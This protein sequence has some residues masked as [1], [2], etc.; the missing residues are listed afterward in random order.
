M[1]VTTEERQK[2]RQEFA[3][4]GVVGDFLEPTQ[5]KYTYYLHKPMLNIKGRIVKAINT[6]FG[7]I[8]SSPDYVARMAA[9]GRY[10]YPCGP[11]CSCPWAKGRDWS[12]AHLQPDG[13]YV[14]DDPKYTPTLVISPEKVKELEREKARL[15]E[16]IAQIE[17]ERNAPAPVVP[18]CL[19]CGWQGKEC[20]DEERAQ[21]SLHSHNARVHPKNKKKSK[22]PRRTGYRARPEASVA[23]PEEAV[24]LKG[25]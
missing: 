9:R 24:A 23:V 1:A 4:L 19:R 2:L 14:E 16:S 22:K 21:A 5:P 18:E 8:P 15:T 12:K 20:A 10:P 17:A 13:T 3:R 7:D 25:D 11:M 6:P